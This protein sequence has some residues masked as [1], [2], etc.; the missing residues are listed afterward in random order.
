M[1]EIND[2]I[3]GMIRIPNYAHNI[4]KTR[5]FQRLSRIKQLGASY[6][7]WP[8]ATHTRYE[9]SIGCMYLSL[10]YAQS[11]RFS[12]EK[13]RV[14][15]M[16]C[17]LHDIAHGP[18]SHAF[19]TAIQGT[20]L[21]PVFGDHDT[22]R[23]HLLLH[24]TQLMEAVGGIGYAIDIINVWKGTYD[25]QC[26][27]LL[28]GAFGVDRL[29]YIMRDIRQTRPVR[30]LSLTCIQTIINNTYIKPNHDGVFFRRKIL[31]V[32][33][34]FLDERRY[35]YEHVYWHPKTLYFDALLCAALKKPGLADQVFEL[36]SD[37]DDTCRFVQLDD[38]YILQRAYDKIKSDSNCE[39]RSNSSDSNKNIYSY[40][41][42]LQ[43]FQNNDETLVSF[44]NTS[45]TNEQHQKQWGA[46]E[47]EF[48]HMYIEDEDGTVTTLFNTYKSMY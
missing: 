24:D 21:Q 40:Q 9:H 15:A 20:R 30:T 33:K 7:V 2:A 27:T 34:I 19:E 25:S 8:N 10:Q 47:L 39:C 12:A 17:L 37:N 26:T 35:L 4:I 41:E 42:L 36:L 11:L 28:S 16:A 38:G 22:Y 6:L 48:Q 1:H 3:Y 31:D 29:D 5:L 46:T 18:F 45:S 14:F 13:T 43:A 44:K 32:L 23:E